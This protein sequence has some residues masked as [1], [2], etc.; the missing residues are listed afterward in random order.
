MR[1]PHGQPELPA[2]AGKKGTTPRVLEVRKYLA[3]QVR[4]CGL[5]DY[6]YSA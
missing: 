2:R 3:S 6:F 4:F 5:T 1:Q